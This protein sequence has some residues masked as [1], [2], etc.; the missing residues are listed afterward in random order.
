MQLRRKEI[1]YNDGWGARKQVIECSASFPRKLK[2]KTDET[3]IKRAYELR[4]AGFKEMN[5]SCNRYGYVYEDGQV[6]WFRSEACYARLGSTSSVRNKMRPVYFVDHSTSYGWFPENAWDALPEYEYKYV[7]GQK[8]YVDWII[9]HS[10]FAPMFID[11][12]VE[13]TCEKGNIVDMRKWSCRAAVSALATVR[14]SIEYP[15][16]SRTFAALSKFL[17]P[18]AAYAFTYVL[19]YD[20]KKDRFSAAEH[21]GHSPFYQATQGMFRTLIKGDLPEDRRKSFQLDP[22][23]NGRVPWISCGN[24]KKVRL[25][26]GLTYHTAKRKFGE[27][28]QT[29]T[30]EDVTKRWIETFI[31]DNLGEEYVKAAFA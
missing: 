6:T 14:S 12:D 3:L 8:E 20:D 30:N 26:E 31:R 9:N 5:R 23:Y 17:T 1:E 13:A 4:E 29:E 11:K 10:M 2:M 16:F 19:Y 24:E 15:R 7:P 21:H 18:H 27:K 22:D 25:P 28:R